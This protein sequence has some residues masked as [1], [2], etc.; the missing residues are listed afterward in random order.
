[1]GM[2]EVV[3]R[4]A[5]GGVVGGPDGAMMSGGMLALGGRRVDVPARL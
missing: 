2:E 1:M 5:E 4:G 3:G